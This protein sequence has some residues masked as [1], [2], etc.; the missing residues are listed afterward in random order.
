[1]PLLP[2]YVTI[3]SLL[4]TLKSINLLQEQKLGMARQALRRE[5]NFVAPMRLLPITN[6]SLA[7]SL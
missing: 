5:D 1:M 4:V 2:V 3:F 7:P 6:H